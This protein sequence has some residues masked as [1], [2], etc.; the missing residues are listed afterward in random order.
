MTTSKLRRD[1]IVG[2][3]HPV[4]LVLVMAYCGGNTVAAL[5][6]PFAT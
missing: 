4:V 6:L 3:H 2:A 1:D 5:A